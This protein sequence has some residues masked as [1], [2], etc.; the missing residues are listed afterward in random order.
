M[1]INLRRILVAVDFSETSDHAFDYAV[2]LSRVFSAEIRA[3][4]ILDDPMLYTGTTDQSFR[5]AYER[6]VEGNMERL[7]QRHGC[8]GVRVETAM[9]SGAVF[10]EIIRQA[11]EWNADLIVIGTHGHG[12]AKNLLLGSVAEKVVRKAGCPVLTVRSGQHDFVMP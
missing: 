6:V 4:H 1:S 12:P 11:R 5:D 10:L 2:S 8:E 9:K 3:L 7:I